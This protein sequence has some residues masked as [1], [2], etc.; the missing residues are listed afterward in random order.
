MKGG[1]EFCFFRRK[2]R[3]SHSVITAK[4]C[5]SWEYLILELMGFSD[6]GLVLGDNT[7]NVDY[8]M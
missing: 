7:I 2:V 4:E 1:S 6:M 8:L 3:E 5:V